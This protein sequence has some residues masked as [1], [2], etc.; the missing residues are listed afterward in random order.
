MR[1]GAAQ[2]RIGITRCD[3]LSHEEPRI[4]RF[5]YDACGLEYAV[6]LLYSSRAIA[7]IM[8]RTLGKNEKRQ[9]R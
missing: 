1:L 8:L 2:E 4:F 3:G 9:R 6:E 7:G 5:M